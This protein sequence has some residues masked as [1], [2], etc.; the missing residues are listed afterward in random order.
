MAAPAS[1]LTLRELA[2]KP[3]TELR[4]VGPKLADRLAVMG[5]DDRARS[6]ARTTRAATTTGRNEPRSRELAVGEEAT[7]YAEVKKV[8]AAERDRQGRTIVEA[9]V[10]DGTSLLHVMFFNQPW[11]EKQLA[12]GTEA[13]FF[14][15]GRAATGAGAR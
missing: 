12:V 3:V 14:G 15:Q 2:A 4:D 11:R 7:V 6:A 5:I 10:F 13:A 8:V 9:E 1:G